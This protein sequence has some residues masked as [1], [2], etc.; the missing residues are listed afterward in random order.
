MGLAI[1][2]A[3]SVKEKVWYHSNCSNRGK[4]CYNTQL[5][6]KGGCCIWYNEPQYL[7]EIEE[8]LGVTID[9]VGPEL[10][11]PVNEYDGKVVYGQ[12]LKRKGPSYEGHVASLAP[13]VKEL[14]QLEKRAQTSYFNLLHQK[15][16]LSR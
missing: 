6:P 15:P 3:A 13:T 4:G 14:Y 11:V 12:K 1:S 10:E 2:F 9:Q 5:V 7:G 16:F 8:H